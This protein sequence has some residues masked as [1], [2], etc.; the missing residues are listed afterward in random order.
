MNLYNLESGMIVVLRNE[1]AFIVVEV[2]HTGVK[3]IINDKHSYI[4]TPCY[5]SYSEDMK[6]IFDSA[7]DICEIYDTFNKELPNDFTIGIENAFKKIDQSMIWH[8][9][10]ISLLNNID[11]ME[12]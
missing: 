2:G 5:S 11:R 12:A 1:E 7:L 8:R 3:L 6:H 4:I 9:D 10:K